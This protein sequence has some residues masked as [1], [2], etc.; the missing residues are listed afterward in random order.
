MQNRAKCKLCHAIIESF[1]ATDYVSCKCGEISVDGGDA[2]R[3]AA[4]QWH[5][6][7]RVD[8]NGNEIVVT[9][10]GDVQPANKETQGKPT[11]KEL[12]DMLDEMVK[13]IERLP[14]DAM[15]SPITHYDFYAGLLLLS[16]ILRAI[17][18]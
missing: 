2:M 4:N 8:D 12:L 7:L 1:H 13:N 6:F 10:K 17:D 14:V 9:V 3:C 11:K 16:S 15:N 18:E 5:N